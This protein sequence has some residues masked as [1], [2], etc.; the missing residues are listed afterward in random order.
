MIRFL[1]A[2][3][4]VCA[5][6]LFALP[7]SAGFEVCNDGLQKQTV[8]IAYR[9]NGEW[10]SEG[11]WS[12]NDGECKMLK[13]GDLKSRYFYYRIKADGGTFVGE[14]YYFC[15]D[16]K[17]FTIEGKSDCEA[18]GFAKEEF[19]ELDTGDHTS[20]KLTLDAPAPSSASKDDIAKAE[21]SPEPANRSGSLGEPFTVNGIFQGCESYDNQSNCSF[22]A[23]GF[24]WYA[25]GGAGTPDDVMTALRTYNVGQL[26]T[27]SGDLISYGDITAEAAV[28]SVQSRNTSSEADNT[29]MGLQGWWRSLDDP[30]STMEIVGAEVYDYYD[31]DGV[32]EQYIRYDDYCPVAQGLA[33]PFIVMTVPE[34]YNDPQCFIIAGWDAIVLQLAYVGGPGG[35]FLNFER[36]YP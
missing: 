11:W 2:V 22:H 26:V 15:T 17:A 35:E 30:S 36:F 7:A 5:S 10:V 28:Y 16:T 18:R 9:S 3:G 31:G 14:D 8:A 20:F 6:W 12:V 25:F 21:P 4:L 13:G 24:K 29:M 27:V 1:S 23:N 33:G 32:L 19:S 34:N